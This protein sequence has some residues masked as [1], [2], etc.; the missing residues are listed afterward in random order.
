MSRLARSSSSIS[1]FTTLEA[2]P[3]ISFGWHVFCLKL[4]YKKKKN[5]GQQKDPGIKTNQPV[6]FQPFQKKTFRIITLFKKVGKIESCLVSKKTLNWPHFTSAG[7]PENLRKR[8]LGA[9]K[10]KAG[11]GMSGNKQERFEKNKNEYICSPYIGFYS[12]SD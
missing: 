10:G 4:N 2:K 11:A 8:A 7:Q 1:F 9:D 12:K 3:A 6:R 5:Y